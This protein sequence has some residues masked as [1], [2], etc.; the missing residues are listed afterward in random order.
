ML[1]WDLREQMVGSKKT[2]VTV[3]SSTDLD[4]IQINEGKLKLEESNN[5]SSSEMIISLPT[6]SELILYVIIS[7][8]CLSIIGCGIVIVKKVLDK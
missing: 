8:A 4:E 2:T 1:D 7:F 5:Y 6:G 3:Y